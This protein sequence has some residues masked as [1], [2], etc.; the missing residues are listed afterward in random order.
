MGFI[1]RIHRFQTTFFCMVFVLLSACNPVPLSVVASDFSINGVKGSGVVTATGSAQEVTID[2][3][4]KETCSTLTSLVASV[5][6]DEGVNISPAP[7]VARDYTAPVTF[8]VTEAYG[9]KVVY[10][11]TV[12][13]K[14]CAA[15]TTTTSGTTN[16]V[17]PTCTLATNGSTGYSL[18]FKAC[19]ASNAATYFDKTEC[20]RDN[21]TGLIW[22]GKTTSGLRASDNKYN[23]LDSTSLLQIAAN[24]VPSTTAL[25]ARSPTQAEI[26]APDNSVGYKN[27]VNALN[28][29]GSKAWR[30]PTHDELQT[31]RVPGST[32][33]G[34]GSGSMTQ[35]DL[36]WFSNTNFNGYYATSTQFGSQAERASVIQFGA[37]TVDNWLRD[38]TVWHPTLGALPFRENSVR[39]VR[40]AF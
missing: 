13:G 5:Q 33:S 27:N 20:V 17:S 9:G 14:T 1:H 19:D 38:G 21:T 24:N 29:C 32:A 34:S 16:L 23:N 25:P 37:G 10:N 31:L 7:A 39:L 18:V 30:M 12:K 11:V 3:T 22:E 40:S 35:I 36:N 28:L 15:N 6:L 2:L 26:D 4:S 8:T